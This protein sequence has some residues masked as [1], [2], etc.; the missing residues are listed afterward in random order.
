MRAA[1]DPCAWPLHAPTCRSALPE[2]TCRSVPRGAPLCVPHQGLSA[3]HLCGT[4]PDAHACVRP[5]NTATSRGPH[6]DRLRIR[7]QSG[8]AVGE[9]PGDT[10]QSRYPAAAH[11]QLRDPKHKTPRVLGLDD[12]A[13]KKGN[14]Y[15]TLLVDLQARC[16]VEVLPD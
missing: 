16:P 6:G 1:I 2:E 15:G 8:G 14:R 12:F 3:H 10:Y 13:W 9:A 11:P 5:S 4:L 7:R